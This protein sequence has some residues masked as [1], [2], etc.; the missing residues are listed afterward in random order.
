VTK[1]HFHSLVSL[2]SKVLITR[3]DR[4]EPPEMAVFSFFTPVKRFRN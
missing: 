1:S 3:Y 4:L 2:E